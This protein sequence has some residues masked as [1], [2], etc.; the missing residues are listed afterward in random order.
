L[1]HILQITDLLTMGLWAI[2]IVIVVGL[3]YELYTLSK[4]S[5]AETDRVRDVKRM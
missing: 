4:D 3:L 1:H 2:K 5:L